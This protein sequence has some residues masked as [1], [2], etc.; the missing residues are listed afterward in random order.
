MLSFLKEDNLKDAKTTSQPAGGDVDGQ[1]GR[2]DQD[3]QNGYYL[4]P[5]GYGKN[6]KQTT[7]ALIAIS[8]VGAVIVWSMVKGVTPSDASASQN[9]QTETH[10]TSVLATLNGIEKDMS[11]KLDAMVNKIYGFS[12]INHVDVSELKKNPFRRDLS[13]GT[14]STTPSEK[15]QLDWQREEALRRSQD[16]Q[17]WS[18]METPQGNCCMINGMINE[19]LLYVGDTIEG[20]TV[21]AISEKYVDLTSGDITVKLKMAE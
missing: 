20:F 1:D 19:K 5:T 7:I 10:I 4:Q 18:I 16:L 9:N 3:G 13:E 15:Q 11:T 17:L 8:C 14:E 2:G 6:L 21:V 12:E